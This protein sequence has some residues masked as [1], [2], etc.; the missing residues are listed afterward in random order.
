MFGIYGPDEKQVVEL[1]HLALYAMQHRGRDGAG[2]AVTDSETI[3]SY[4]D[5]GLVADVFT[6]KVL[7]SMKTG[8]IA[9]GHVRNSRRASPSGMSSVTD[10][11]LKPPF[12]CIVRLLPSWLV[13]LSMC[14]VVEDVSMPS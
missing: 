10:A 4:K 7:K 11:I 12:T 8:H 6:A 9:I 1:S 3:Y 2:I 13:A 5:L 14:F